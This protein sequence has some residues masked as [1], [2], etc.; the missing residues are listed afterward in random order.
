MFRSAPFILIALIALSTVGGASAASVGSTQCS[1]ASITQQ[2]DAL[3]Q[4]VN[5]ASAESVATT[6][7]QFSAAAT[8]SVVLF[9]SVNV[10]GSYGDSCLVVATSVNVVY[11]VTLQN[12]TTKQLTVV[13]SPLATAVEQVVLSNVLPVAGTTVPSS[14]W[15]GYEFY[16]GP[17]QNTNLLN[18]IGGY[19]N[20]TKVSGSWVNCTLNG[21][22]WSGWAGLSPDLG[23]GTNSTNCTSGCIAQTGF[24]STVTCS[25]HT[26][27]SSY[28]GWYEFLPARVV[29]CNWSP[30]PSSGDR[31]FG[32]VMYSS[33]TYTVSLDDK[34]SSQTCSSSSSSVPG[35]S[36]YYVEYMG[37]DNSVSGVGYLPTF[38]RTTFDTLDACGPSHCYNGYNYYSN[39]WYIKDECCVSTTTPPYSN[40]LVGSLSS[41]TWGYSDV[42]STSAGT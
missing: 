9:N 1:E 7:L 39:G 22:Y 29:S 14:N 23:G 28:E 11:D 2:S 16:I 3:A 15:A 33:G 12:G 34:T 8:D 36:P 17:S 31:L 42:Y 37:E 19:F 4:S 25:N 21:C 38:G 32:D 5:Q 6:S 30:S 40:V 18:S 26:C 20:I 13:E 10:S 35:G 24:L 41:S 27:S